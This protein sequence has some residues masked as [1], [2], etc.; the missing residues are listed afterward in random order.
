[1]SNQ[2]AYQSTLVNAIA[3]CM[4]G[5]DANNILNLVVSS[6]DG[7]RKL[8]S[9]QSKRQGWIPFISTTDDA[10]DA[11]YVVSTT[12][13]GVTY[14]SLTSELNTNIAN[15]DF[16][17][18]LTFYSGV[19]STPGFV[20]V[21]SSAAVTSNNLASSSNN[22]SGLQDGAIA[23]VVVG[24]FA[25]VVILI[26][27]GYWSFSQRSKNIPSHRK[28]YPS[29]SSSIDI[30]GQ[31]ASEL[32]KMSSNGGCSI[33]AEGVKTIQNHGIHTVSNPIIKASA[34]TAMP[35]DGETNSSMGGGDSSMITS[36]IQDND[37]PPVVVT[38]VV[39][40]KK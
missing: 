4:E 15:G 7:R 21:T 3:A 28:N 34:I 27:L 33:E 8:R 11:S 32:S 25:G 29:K 5:I 14:S 38:A 1:M 39:D 40:E 23:G 19:Y 26:A 17:G 13:V 12:E 30:P 35:M 18:Y 36:F 22:S 20:N 37:A 9:S 6:D 10:I 16:S 31:R 2:T 24:G